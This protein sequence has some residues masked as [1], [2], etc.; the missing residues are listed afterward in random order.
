MSRE[1]LP[2]VGAFALVSALGFDEGGYAATAWGWSAVVLFV[3]LAVLLARGAGLPRPAALCLVTA[4]AALTAWTAASTLWSSDRTDSVLEVERTLVYLAAAALFVLAGSAPALLGGVLGAATLL[5]GYGLSRWLLGD[6]EVPLS[7]DPQAGER[8]SEPVGYANGVAILAALGLLLAV[9]FAARAVRTGAAAGAAAPVPLLAATLYFTFGRGAWLA[10]AVGLVASIAIGPRRLQL[11]L[12]AVGLSVPAA[13]AVLAANRL[14]ASASVAALLPLLCLLSASVPV[15]LRL[16]ENVYRPPRHLRMAFAAV[17]IALPL[18]AAAAVLVKLGGP[19][20]AYDSFKA[21]P[22]PAHADAESRVLSL[23][24]SNR[25]DYWGV[26]WRSYREEPL[27]GT[28]AGTFERTWL[29]DRPVPQPVRDAHTLY[30]ETLAELGPVGLAVLLLALAVP[31]AGIGG[32]WAAVALGPYAAFL[33]HAAQDWDWELPAVTVAGL[34]CGAAAITGQ[35]RRPLPRAAAVLATGLALLAGAAYG[36]NYALAQ[37]NAAADRLE[38]NDARAAARRARTLQPWSPEPWRVL[39]ETELADG[40]L[41]AAR[42]S[43]RRGL[44]NDPDDWELWLDLGLASDAQARR[45]AFSRAALLNPLS[46]EL[47]ELGFKRR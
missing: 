34:A 11:A 7:A 13:L 17:L 6:P 25:A 4:L 31:F 1:A 44:E 28:G 14:G 33:A 27:L 21:A 29:R 20:G 5:C 12:M 3:F 24:G 45:E 35:G 30:L 38:S 37:A 46:P 8:L 26:A 10:L 16:A 40:S 36:G 15:A 23:S 2:A 19:G 32:R 18:L 47:R 42:R 39:G 43:F 9:G 22:A 41:E